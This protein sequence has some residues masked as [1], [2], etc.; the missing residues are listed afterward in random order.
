MEQLHSLFS[1][2][3]LPEILFIFNSVKKYSLKDFSPPLPKP[4]DFHGLFSS[5]YFLNI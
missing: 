3:T 5:T 1:V 2:I 4:L